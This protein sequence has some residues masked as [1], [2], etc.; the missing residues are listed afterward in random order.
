MIGLGS[1]YWYN[2]TKSLP[3]SIPKY[4][5]MGFVAFLFGKWLYRN[6]F[7]RRL[8]ESHA[9]TPYMQAMRRS[10]GI[11][12]A[13][14]SEFTDPAFGGAGGGSEF[15]GWSSGG[16]TNANYTDDRQ[17]FRSGS[18]QSTDYSLPG[19]ENLDNQT[20]DES[21]KPR[22]TYD[23]LRARNRGFIK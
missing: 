9:T 13:T 16:P 17:Q 3:H 10:L 11:A 18:S 5:G 22:L 1:L 12:P 23:E 7:K 8:A 2:K 4:M 21:A 20:N 15:D 19:A 6:E 14:S